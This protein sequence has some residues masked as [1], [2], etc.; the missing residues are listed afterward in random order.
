MVTYDSAARWLR[1]A[2]RDRR[3]FNLVFTENVSYGFRRNLFGVRWIGGLV[4][5]LCAVADG[6]GLY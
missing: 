4:A 2:T 6:G 5:L 3:Q 1:K